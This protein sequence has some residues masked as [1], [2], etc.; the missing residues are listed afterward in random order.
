MN[1]SQSSMIQGEEP[2]MYLQ[3]PSSARSQDVSHVLASTFRQLFTR[4][5]VA[6]DTVQYLNTSRGGE[7]PYHEAYVEALQKVIVAFQC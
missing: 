4:D 2:A 5:A 6:P 3:R 7:D 1:A